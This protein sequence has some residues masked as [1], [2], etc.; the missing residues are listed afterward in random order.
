MKHLWKGRAGVG[1]R[2]LC[3]FILSWNALR[4]GGLLSVQA[5]RELVERIISALSLQGCRDR[6]IGSSER[7]GISG[8]E[9]CANSCRRP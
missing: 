1:A 5:K 7:R 4:G 2:R 3:G 6:L 8:G 9:V